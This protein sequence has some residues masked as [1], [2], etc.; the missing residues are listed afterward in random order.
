MA[1]KW[2]VFLCPWVVPVV[3]YLDARVHDLSPRIFALTP[4]TWWY[5]NI[6]LRNL[7]IVLGI[8][9]SR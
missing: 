5:D 4:F 8:N 2:L 7:D 3:R 6:L 9:L 1:V